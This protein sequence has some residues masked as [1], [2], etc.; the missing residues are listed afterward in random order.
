MHD[1]VALAAGGGQD[2]A[3]HPHAA[4]AHGHLV[5]VDADV[6][7]DR[8]DQ[9][10]RGHVGVPVHLLGRPRDD[11]DD[12]GQRRVR[13]L[14]AGDLV[15]RGAAGRRRGRAAGDV[16]R[17]AGQGAPQADRRQSLGSVLMRPT[18]G[19]LRD[20]QAQCRTWQDR[21]MKSFAIKVVVNAVAIWIATLVTGIS[22]NGGSNTT[23]GKV[24]TFLFIG[25]LFG[26]VNSVVKP[27]VKLF[28]FPFYILTLGLITFVV[29]ALMLELTSGCPGTRRCSCGST[30]SG[31]RPW[32]RRWSSPSCR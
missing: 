30:T 31:G 20:R 32:E 4:G 12:A 22:V 11:L 10:G 3:E 5:G 14:V 19:A 16:A 6:G 17:D 23:T 15:R 24:L 18:L 25:L 27:V 13:V 1:L 26:I 2:L 7:R 21:G 9:I 29:N 8:L 28:A